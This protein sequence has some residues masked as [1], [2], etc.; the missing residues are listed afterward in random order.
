[1]PPKEDAPIRH[2]VSLER[3]TAFGA[4]TDETTTS[5]IAHERIGGRIAVEIEDPT[6]MSTLIRHCHF[7]FSARIFQ[8][9][10]V[11]RTMLPQVFDHCL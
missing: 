9:P 8:A 5:A 7:P 6:L 10:H 2:V 3:T 11:Q 1:M 4:L